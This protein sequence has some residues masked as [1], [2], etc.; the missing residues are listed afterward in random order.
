MSCAMSKAR[1]PC[2]LFLADTLPSPWLA[3]LTQTLPT[4]MKQAAQSV[5]TA[6]PSAVVLC[7]GILRNNG[8]QLTHHV[9]LNTLL[10]IML[11]RNSSSFASSLKDL[12]TIFP[13]P[14]PYTAIMMPLVAWSRIPPTMPMSNTS[15]SNIPPPVTSST[16]S[17]P[18][19]LAFVRQTMSQISLPNLSQ[20]RTSS[21]SVPCWGFNGH[22]PRFRVR[23]S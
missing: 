21:V 14:L 15:A 18:V 6:S 20:N 11:A 19:L 8:G 5:G 7:P 10:S 1:I 4:A 23:R 9:T 3:T 17:L 13:L 16:R 12:G 2:L 22:D